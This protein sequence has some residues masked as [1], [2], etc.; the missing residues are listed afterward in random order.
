MKVEHGDEYYNC[1]CPICGNKFHLK[2]YALSR[3]KRHF[4]SK[5]CFYIAKKDDMKGENNHQY[6]LKGNKNASWISDRKKSRF[7]YV[8]I[9]CLEHPFKD[10]QGFVFEH[11]LIAERF[12]LN[13]TNSVVVNGKKYLSPDFVVHHKNFDRQDNRVE[14]LVV[15]TKEEHQKLHAKLNGAKR[16]MITGRFVKDD[17]VVKVKK[18]TDTAILPERKSIGAAGYDLYI[19]CDEETIVYPHETVTLPTNIAF[20]IPE[21]YFG[22]IYAR[23]GVATKRSL[24][25]ATCVSVIDSDFRGAVTIP[26]HNDSDLP[27]FI[28]PHERIAQIIFQKALFVDLELVEELDETE[29]GSD[30]FGSTGR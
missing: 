1:T 20:S 12:L 4:C 18:V 2:P 13:D 30:G 6:G 22:A 28:E 15:M 11:R 10:L 29:R 8:Q 25:P 5:E 26:I 14:N 17:C 21:N 9:R 23:S 19:D 16:D 7:G 27:K 24:R 3:A